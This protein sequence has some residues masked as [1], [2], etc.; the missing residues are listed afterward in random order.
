MELNA[1]EAQRNNMISDFAFPLA[2]LSGLESSEELL[3]S[4][5]GSK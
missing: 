3:S 5:T 2:V 4:G 1:K